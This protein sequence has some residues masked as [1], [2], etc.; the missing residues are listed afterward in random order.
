MKN[1]R[2]LLHYKTTISL[3]P[4]IQGVISCWSLHHHHHHQP[5]IKTFKIPNLTR[6]C[7]QKFLSTTLTLYIF[8]LYPP[9]PPQCN[10]SRHKI[11]FHSLL[12]V[13]IREKILAI[14]WPL[15]NILK[16]AICSFA[17]I[18]IMYTFRIK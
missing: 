16:T 9:L 11:F 18:K 3:N 4:N 2:K 7:K 10:D 15:L 12:G 6:K 14:N 1:I 13:R 5:G 17:L 8:L